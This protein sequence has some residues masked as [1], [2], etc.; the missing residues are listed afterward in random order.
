MMGKQDK[1]LQIMII[2]IG[3]LIPESH[4]LKKI[5]ENID[6]NFI[7]EKV[8]HLYSKTGR[9]SIDPVLLFKMLLIRIFIWHKIRAEIMRRSKFEYS[10]QVVLWA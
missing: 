2:E 9:K 3:S 7:Y 6:L 4:L 10:V 5:E 8:N 1:Q